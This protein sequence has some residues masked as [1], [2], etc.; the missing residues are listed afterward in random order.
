MRMTV[1]LPSLSNVQAS[2]TATLNAP[3]GRSYDRIIFNYSGVTLAQLKN[4]RVEVDGKPIQEFKDGVQLIDINKYYQ[5]HDKDGFFTL[6]FA[7]P[8]MNSLEHQRLTR[9][10]TG[11]GSGDNAQ[12]VV[13]T[14]QI[15]MDI[16]AAAE[17]PKIEAHAVQSD[18]S[19]LGYITKVKQFVMSSATAG[20]FEIDS[21]PKG[22]RIL[23]IHFFKSDVTKVEVEQN[24]RKITEGSKDL[25]EFLQRESERA[26]MTAKATTVDYTMEQ[27]LFNS[28]ETRPD[29]IRDQRFRLTLASPGEVRVVVEYL[30]G[31]A[32]I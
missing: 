15:S 10:G 14:L 24:S 20:N 9:L 29:L 27:D 25:M 18:P 22:P 23:A 11:V 2:S 28:L 31:F 16:D 21:I 6:W 17:A 32:G 19:P 4:I 26:P 30:D 3:P 8:E 13:Q 5:R 12:G 1:K 7:R